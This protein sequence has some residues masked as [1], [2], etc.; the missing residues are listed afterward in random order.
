MLRSYK[1]WWHHIKIFVFLKTNKQKVIEDK[2]KIFGISICQ[3]LLD[4]GNFIIMKRNIIKA[5]FA[6]ARTLLLVCVNGG[7]FAFVIWQA[8]KCINVYIDKPIGTRLKMEKSTDLTFPT[9]TI[10]GNEI[11]T[12]YN[13]INFEKYDEASYFDNGYAKDN[14]GIR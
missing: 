3:V 5:F 9:I 2:G 14:C 1:P 6:L 8:V 13:T 12:K 7:C 11:K 4:P 10:C